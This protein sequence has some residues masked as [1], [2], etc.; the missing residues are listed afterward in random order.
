MILGLLTDGKKEGI[1]KKNVALELL[2]QSGDLEG[3]RDIETEIVEEAREEII[4]SSE[5]RRGD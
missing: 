2:R 5:I 1:P 3:L 4:W